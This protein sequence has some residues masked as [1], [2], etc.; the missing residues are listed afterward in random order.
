MWEYRIF[1][2]D[3]WWGIY[4]RKQQW[5]V[6]I[7]SYLNWHNLWTPHK[8]YAKIFYSEDAVVNALVTM[9]ARDEKKSD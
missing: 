5:N 2:T 1:K 9:K 6:L 7:V 4:K 8:T 3:R